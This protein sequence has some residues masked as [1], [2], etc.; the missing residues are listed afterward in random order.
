MAVRALRAS[1]GWVSM[2]RRPTPAWIAM[3]PM[4]CATMSCSS[5]AIR[6]RSFT[7]AC[8]WACARRASARSAACRSEWPASQAMTVVSTTTTSSCSGSSSP[9]ARKTAGTARTI[10]AAVSEIRR[11]RVA[12]MK[13][14]SMPAAA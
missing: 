12:A 11:G 9:S 6:S 14:T 4:L 5:R 1:A 7:A 3:M 8:A 10:R 13:Q 2:T